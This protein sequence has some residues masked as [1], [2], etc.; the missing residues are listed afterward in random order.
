MADR[1]ELEENCTRQ[2]TRGR[3]LLGITQHTGP[4]LDWSPHASVEDLST[5]WVLDTTRRRS[6]CCAWCGMA[7]QARVGNSGPAG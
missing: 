3:G 2:T 7:H 5:Y 4:E 6:D 1:P